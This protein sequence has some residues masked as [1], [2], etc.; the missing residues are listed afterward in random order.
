LCYYY[1]TCF[2]NEWSVRKTILHTKCLILKSVLHTGC[3]PVTSQHYLLSYL[4]R[5]Q[6]LYF[7]VYKQKHLGQSQGNST[8]RTQTLSS[9]IGPSRSLHLFLDSMLLL[10]LRWRC[11]SQADGKQHW[12]WPC[13][14]GR[15]RVFSSLEKY[16][17]P[18][19]PHTERCHY[20]WAGL[21]RTLQKTGF[22]QH[23]SFVLFLQSMLGGSSPALS[24][25]WTDNVNSPTG[26]AAASRTWH[27]GAEPEPLLLTPTLEFFSPDLSIGT[28]EGH[29]PQDRCSLATPQLCTDDPGISKYKVPIRYLSPVSSRVHFHHSWAESTS[30]SQTNKSWEP[31]TNTMSAV[32]W[33]WNKFVTDSAVKIFLFPGMGYGENIQ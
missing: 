3:T 21:Q 30:S 13:S 28:F 8:R 2:E 18:L 4:S 23:L 24:L 7:C 1:L 32:P 19:D 29:I 11:H 22:Q 6:R 14:S 10:G 5:P 27:S 31:W 15:R 17:V 20:S 33:N 9:G 12:R 26:L 16:S 25:T